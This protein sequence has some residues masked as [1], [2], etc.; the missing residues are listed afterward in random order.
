M[1]FDEARYQHYIE[2]YNQ[3]D[4]PRLAREF[5]APDVV[6]ELEELRLQG[7]DFARFLVDAHQGVK[8]VL[9]PVRILMSGDRAVVE[10]DIEFRATA[11]LPHF[12]LKPLK[13]GE[14]CATRW[15]ALYRFAGDKIIELVLFRWA[16]DTRK[17][18]TWPPTA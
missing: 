8:E 13:A 10:M 17:S 5:F 4:W 1:A 11:D 6:V 12:L 18:T 7:E 9:R 15:C 14:S 3:E 2:V 16:P